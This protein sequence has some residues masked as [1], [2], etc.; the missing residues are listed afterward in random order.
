MQTDRF[1][2]GLRPALVALVGQVTGKLVGS[3]ANRHWLANIHVYCIY[4]ILI[5]GYVFLDLSDNIFYK[6]KKNSSRFAIS[7]ELLILQIYV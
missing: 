3:I 4:I 6:L 7:A 5:G 1:S 2:S